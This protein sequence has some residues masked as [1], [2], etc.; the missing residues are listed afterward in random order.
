MKFWK[1]REQSFKRLI[2]TKNAKIIEVV[3]P[4]QS[5]TK[6]NAGNFYSNVGVKN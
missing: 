3:G 1:I 6:S 4:V 2:F 5:I